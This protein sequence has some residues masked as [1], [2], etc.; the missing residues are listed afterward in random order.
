MRTVAKEHVAQ[1]DDGES[2]DALLRRIIGEYREM[3]GLCLTAPQAQRLWHLDAAMCDCILAIL[4]DQGFLIRTNRGLYV[5][6]E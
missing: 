4:V 1:P 3:P 5:R 2:I 6:R